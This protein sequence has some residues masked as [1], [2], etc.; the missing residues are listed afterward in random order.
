MRSLRPTL[1]VSVVL[2]VLWALPLMAEGNET[3]KARFIQGYVVDYSG[4]TLVLNEHWVVKITDDT[5]LLNSEGEG[6]KKS[7]LKENLWVYVEGLEEADGQIGAVK[8]YLLPDY[9]SK[10]DRELYPFIKIP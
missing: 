7:K 8:I 10:E 9:V 3:G 1:M 4:N 2:L 6:L 5:E